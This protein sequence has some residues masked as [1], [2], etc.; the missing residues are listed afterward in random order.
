[1][2]PFVWTG[3][4]GCSTFNGVQ[5]LVQDDLCECVL[6]REELDVESASESLVAVTHC[7]SLASS[8]VS[9]HGDSRARSAISPSLTSRS[10][11]V[12][13]RLPCFMGVGWTKCNAIA[14]SL[15]KGPLGAVGGG[16][17]S[18]RPVPGAGGRFFFRRRFLAAFSPA[19]L[20]SI[21]VSQVKVSQTRFWTS[22][23]CTNRDKVG[24]RDPPGRRNNA[25]A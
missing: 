23:C 25:F 8:A 7:M 3:S 1:M 17:G 12:F 22:F 20:V 4:R 15:R 14:R 21:A 2:I 18:R 13:R 10:L 6:C 9:R 16:G 5:F 19:T 11:R 24:S